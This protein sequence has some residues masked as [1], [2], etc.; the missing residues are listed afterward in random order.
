M[1]LI[2]SVVVKGY[3]AHEKPEETASGQPS[4][5]GGRVN[6]EGRGK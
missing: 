3:R 2:L 1:D 6:A 4:I 5:L